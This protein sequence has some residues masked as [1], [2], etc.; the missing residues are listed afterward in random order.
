MKELKTLYKVI[1]RRKKSNFTAHTPRP[2]SARILNK[3]NK[4]Y[5]NTNAGQKR[6]AQPDSESHKSSNRVIS[7]RLAD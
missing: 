4:H 2:L 7:D 5:I 6:L 3:Y 1:G